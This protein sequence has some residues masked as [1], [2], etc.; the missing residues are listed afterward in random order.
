MKVIAIIFVACLLSGCASYKGYV[1][2]PADRAET[3]HSRLAFS[4]HDETTLAL[5]FGSHSRDFHIP[6]VVLWNRETPPYKL[7]L[8]ASSRILE[9]NQLEITAL[10]LVMPDD[11]TYDILAET[12]L[13]LWFEQVSTNKSAATRSRVTWVSNPLPLDFSKGKS[14][15]VRI[16]GTL[17]TKIIRTKEHFDAVQEKGL[18]S[19]FT[20][21]R[22][23]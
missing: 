11:T 1:Y 17:G 19:I 6:F 16:E 5:S 14:V 18:G 22:G 21:Y 10:E 23:L 20:L 12:P 9:T 8:Y 4:F 15:S 3:K 7:H 2:S 13:V